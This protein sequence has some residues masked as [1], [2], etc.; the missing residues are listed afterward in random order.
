MNTSKRSFPLPDQSKFTFTIQSLVLS[1][2]AGLVICFGLSPS[3]F[4]DKALPAGGATE[5]GAE[6]EDQVLLHK[7]RLAM[8]DSRFNDAEQLLLKAVSLNSK[9]ADALFNLG[10]VQGRLGK[11]LPSITQERK[12]LELK[13]N[14]AA[15]YTVMGSSLAGMGKLKEA[16]EALATAIKLDSHNATSYV[17]RAAVK[18][19]LKDYQG[20]AALYGQAI[21]IS[22]NYSQAY[23]GLSTALGKLGDKD[24]QLKAAREAVRV[25]PGSAYAHGRLGFILSQRGDTGA[26]LSEGF[27]ANALRIQDSWNEFLGMFLTAWASV[28]LA[29]AC[30]FGVIFAGSSFKP[31]EGEQIIRSFFLTF[32]KDKPGRFVVTDTRL[33]FVPESF[34]SWFGA[35]RVSIQRPQIES[36]NYLSTLGGGTVSILTRDQSV[37]QFRMPLLVLDPLR[38]LLISQGLTSKDPAE[39]AIPKPDSDV[40][41]DEAKVDE[42]SVAA[43]TVESKESAETGDSEKTEDKQENA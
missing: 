34:S 12:C 16:D 10:Q 13:P 18:G 24:G 1:F 37:H 29:F 22:P 3:A 32:Y 15:A 31:Q 9:N 39:F 25:A 35:T 14:M 36:I 5:N 28:F 7:A 42:Q 21:K 8:Y 26:A 23:L 33:V 2:A 4:A 43:E 6:S 11:Y 40:K 17:N 38:N 20:A 41:A 19:M 30:I 27:R